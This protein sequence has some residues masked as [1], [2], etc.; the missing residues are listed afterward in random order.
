[1][2][3]ICTVVDKVQKPFFKIFAKSIISKS[4]FVS[5]VYVARVNEIGKEYIEIINNIKF[6]YFNFTL[7]FEVPCSK[8]VMSYNHAVG[9]HK[10]IDRVKTDYVMLSDCDI[11]FFK[12]FDEYYLNAFETNNLNIIGIQMYKIAAQKN[13]VYSFDSFPGIHNCMMKTNSL[14][15]PQMFKDKLFFTDSLTNNSSLKDINYKIYQN[16]Y[17]IMGCIEDYIDLY[18]HKNGHFDTG[19]NLLIW[20]ELNKGKYLT[21]RPGWRIVGTKN[22][23]SNTNIILPKNDITLMFHQGGIWESNK[24]Y[25][26]K[27]SYKLFNII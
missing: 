17:L 3:S 4:K 16:Y 18:D 7:P 21:F 10:C 15:S 8:F 11:F 24:F 12:D 26:F 1:M 23:V 20:N 2:I 13:F 27:K 9:L 14:P 6:H 25:S 22:W 19:C 5:N